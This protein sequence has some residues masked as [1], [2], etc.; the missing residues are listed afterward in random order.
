MK[1]PILSICIPTYNRST[2]LRECLDS[3]LSSAKEYESKIEIVI[4][5][6]AST[7][8]TQAVVNEY[9]KMHSI[10]RYHRNDRNLGGESNFYIAAEKASGKYIWILGDDDKV[11]IKSVPIILNQINCGYDLTILNCSIWSRDFST[12]LKQY[13]ISI[14]T[15]IEY[16]NH[17]E[18]LQNF[19]VYLGYIS[20]VVV[21][22]DLFLQTSFQD[23]S[24]Y[25][26][27]SLSFLY[28][29]YAAIINITKAIYIA[30]PLVYNRS[31]NSPVTDWHNKFIIGST[32][33]FRSL[34]DRGYDCKAVN[35]AISLELRRFTI[36]SII[37]KKAFDSNNLSFSTKR[38]LSIY[39]HDRLFLFVVM[40]ILCVPIP[41]QLMRMGI[42]MLKR[43][44]HG[45]G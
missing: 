17:N 28:T 6:N 40:P 3:V 7:D 39:K 34:Q 18:I 2:Q 21:K 30:T 24:K 38:L 44:Y 45:R 20:S 8:N 19:G 16:N 9:M 32:S 1:C 26:K 23:H 11:A 10:I 36:P 12:L 25:I 31:E 5:D 35:S 22:R 13:N 37:Y 33:I 4:S 41:K 15:N 43:I 14:Y 42:K 27:F 29:T